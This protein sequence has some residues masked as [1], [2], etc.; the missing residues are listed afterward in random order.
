MKNHSPVKNKRVSITFN[1]ANGRLVVRPKTVAVDC[2]LREEVLWRCRNADLEIR[3]NPDE[4]PFRTSRWRCSQGGGCLSG[5]PRKRRV[6]EKCV[7]YT[8]TVLPALDAEDNGHA[9]GNGARASAAKKKKKAAA[10][11]EVTN[12]HKPIVREAFLLLC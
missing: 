9:N 4:T 6:K 7:R 11:A 2:A 1:P 3:F 12:G 10:T 5:V 8:V